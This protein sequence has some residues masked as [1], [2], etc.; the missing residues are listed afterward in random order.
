MAG[1]CRGLASRW[2]LNV[3][4]V[5]ALFVLASA[6]AGLGVLAYVACWLVLPLDVDDDDSPS[7]VRGMASLALLAA[8]AAGLVTIGAAAAATTVFGFGW[9]VAIAACVFLVAALVAWP[10]VRP[11][12]AL[13]AL[14][15]AALPAVAVLASGV[16]IMPQA[17]LVT[18]APTS[19]AD[20]PQGGYHA[21]L[22]ELF[23]DLRGFHAPAGSIVPLRLET[24]TGAT[25]VALPRDRCFNL[26]IRYRTHRA[27]PLTRALSRN[28]SAPTATFY[29][30]GM[31]ADG[32][33]HRTSSDPRAATI[34]IDYTAVAGTLTVRDYPSDT[35]P[36]F[37]RDW[38]ENIVAP[39]SP[40][41]LNWAW[42]ESVRTRAVQ[43][44]WRIWHKQ[45]ARWSRRLTTLL[46][47]ACA[48]PTTTPR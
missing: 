35:G 47:G 4:Q 48:S 15:A 8:S 37:N 33:W 46:A 45:M 44:R 26:D 40:S 36:L 16:R 39:A 29:A 3:A 23:V 25:V 5:R 28:T 18:H 30:D 10:V 14:L 43:H 13:A 20:L 7:L 24:G 17:G 41:D 19:T 31:P 21:G 22:G 27:W 1:V 11:A 32:H 6:L 9:A 38:P 42:R 2:D 34:A 12:W